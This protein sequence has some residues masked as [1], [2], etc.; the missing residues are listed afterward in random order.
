[1]QKPFEGVLNT[2]GGVPKISGGG[3]ALRTRKSVPGVRQLIDKTMKTN[4]FDVVFS[5]K[6]GKPNV[7]QL[8]QLNGSSDGQVSAGRKRILGCATNPVFSK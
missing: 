6:T 4:L 2:S 1:M 3:W 8:E 7:N 5:K